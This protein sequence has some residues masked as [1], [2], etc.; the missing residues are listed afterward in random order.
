MAFAGLKKDKD[1]NDIVTYLKE[2]VR[3]PRCYPVC[4]A[5][6][7]IGDASDR[8]KPYIGTLDYLFA[9]PYINTTWLSSIDTTCISSAC[10]PHSRHMLHLRE[11]S[12]NC[13]GRYVT[14]GIRTPGAS[15]TE[16]LSLETI[17]LR[18]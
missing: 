3:V 18:K 6:L 1:R 2:A 17:V 9:Y 12:K 16:C 8:V 5:P 11:D 7:T 13:F 14:S 15:H 10:I 4:S